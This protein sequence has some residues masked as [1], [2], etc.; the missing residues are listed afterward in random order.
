[1]IGNRLKRRI[2]D[3][4][5]PHLQ[6]ADRIFVVP[7]GALNLV[8][9][10]ALPVGSSSYLM[11]QGPLIHYLSAERDIVQFAKQKPGAAQGLL[12]LGA[13]SFDDES[14]LLPAA[15]IRAA[16]GSAH[17]AMRSSCGSF[18]SLQFA[19]L[20]G[21]L[22]EA[23]GIVRL[24]NEAEKLAPRSAYLL[25]GATASERAFKAH[26][27]G[28]RVLHL[29]T[30]GFFIGADCSLG[31]EGTRPHGRVDRERPERARRNRRESTSAGR[32]GPRRRQPPCAGEAR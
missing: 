10:A 15:E 21:T 27:S 19:P 14:S 22:G 9:L 4:L 5:E 25:T 7:D 31:G 17:T 20:P 2:W 32:I 26:A 12:A 29:A 18:R 1:M 6:G 13:A 16:S 24:W 23:Q 28:R 30:H 11:N 3:P 8:N